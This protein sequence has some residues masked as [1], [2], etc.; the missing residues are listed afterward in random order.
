[1]KVGIIKLVLQM[2]NQLLGRRIR[3]MRRQVHGRTRG[4]DTDGYDK[5]RM[6]HDVGI[7]PPLLRANTG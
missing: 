1:M 2:A 6:G 4:G 5:P 7:T 3:L